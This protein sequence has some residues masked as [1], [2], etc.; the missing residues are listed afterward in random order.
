MMRMTLPIEYERQH[1][2]MIKYIGPGTETAWA[3]ISA[4]SLVSYGTSVSLPL[5]YPPLL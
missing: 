4:L 2:V 5:V 3:H 1:N